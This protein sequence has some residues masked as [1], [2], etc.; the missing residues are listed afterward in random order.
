MNGSVVGKLY[1]LR[2]PE[3]QAQLELKAMPEY[4]HPFYWP[5]FVMIGDWK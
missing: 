5:S 3:R 1:K 4:S 2:E